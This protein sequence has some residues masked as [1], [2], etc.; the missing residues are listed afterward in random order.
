MLSK[1]EHPPI[2]ALMAIESLKEQAARVAEAK[3]IYHEEVGMRDELIRDLKAIKLPD[4][5][6]AGITGLSRD[7][8][9]RIVHSAPR[10]GVS[11]S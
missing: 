2:S 11:R 7:S 4:K 8:I 10:P 1:R 9:H 3:R 5:T 6:I